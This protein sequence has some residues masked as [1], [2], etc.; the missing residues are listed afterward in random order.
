MADAGPNRNGSQFFITEVPTTYLNNRHTL[1]GQLPA[2]S[3]Q[4]NGGAGREAL[5]VKPA[6]AA[7]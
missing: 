7:K 4:G 3:A 6:A 2:A 1:F 5:P